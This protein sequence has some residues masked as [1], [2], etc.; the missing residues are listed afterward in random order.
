MEGNEF[1]QLSCPSF[2][3]SQAPAGE[4]SRSRPAGRG[5]CS[6]GCRHSLPVWLLAGWVHGFFPAFFVSCGAAF[7]GGYTLLSQEADWNS[8]VLPV[9]WH[10]PVL[11]VTETAQRAVGEGAFPSQTNLGTRLLAGLGSIASKSLW[12]PAS[13]PCVKLAAP[14]APSSIRFLLPV[15]CRVLRAPLTAHH[16]QTHPIER[17]WCS[18]CSLA[19]AEGWLGQQQAGQRSDSLCLVSG[20]TKML[21][22][23]EPSS[24]CSSCAAKSRGAAPL[25]GSYQCTGVRWMILW[26][27]DT[28][29]T[30][31]LGLEVLLA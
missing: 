29:C 23:Q 28:F 12:A 3:A 4:G 22:L 8:K 30:A 20:G 18:S 1:L 17:G 27:Y 9:L 6:S 10:F 13:P 15:L 25:P 14:P 31:L 26:L 16:I 21:L 19:R 2:P 5:V 7:S 24:S 11:Q